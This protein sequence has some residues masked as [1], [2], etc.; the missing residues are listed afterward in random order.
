MW[1][2]YLMLD[3]EATEIVQLEEGVLRQ[4]EAPVGSWCICHSPFRCIS[5]S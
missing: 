1:H 5:S 2:S 3:R 4:W